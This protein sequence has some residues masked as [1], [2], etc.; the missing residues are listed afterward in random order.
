MKKKYFLIGAFVALIALIVLVFSASEF[1]IN[2]QWFKDVDYTEMFFI[3]VMTMLKVIIP[4]FVIAFI[5][6]ILYYR[7]LLKGLPKLK[8]SIE[9]VISKKIERGTINGCSN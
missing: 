9:N 7:C 5:G 6:I 8:T 1:I 4:I 2:L 3:R